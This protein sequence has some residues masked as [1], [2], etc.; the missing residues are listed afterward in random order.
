M[1]VAMVVVVVVQVPSMALAHLPFMVVALEA[2]T[3]PPI[4]MEMFP[5]PSSGHS[6]TPAF[7]ARLS[8]ATIMMQVQIL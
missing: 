1:V 5:L 4:G 2:A 6:P 3:M 8:Q 7:G